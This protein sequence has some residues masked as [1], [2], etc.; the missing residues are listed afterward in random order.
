MASSSESL[1]S[2]LSAAHAI[3]LTE[4]AARMEAEAVAASAQA[5]AASAKA[6]AANAPADLSITEALITHL[7]LEKLLR[8]LYGARSEHKARL[9]EQME[10]NH[11]AKATL[12]RVRRIS[13]P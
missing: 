8:Q 1:P 12:N 13:P 2:D 10:R 11:T 5:E 3:I 9:L 4:R 6:E 7:K